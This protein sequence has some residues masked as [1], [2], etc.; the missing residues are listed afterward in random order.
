MSRTSESSHIFAF[1]LSLNLSIKKVKLCLQYVLICLFSRSTQSKID[2][3]FPLFAVCRA[4][5]TAGFSF[6]A[7]SNAQRGCCERLRSCKAGVGFRVLTSAFTNI[8]CA[9]Q[10]DVFKH[11]HPA[12]RLCGE[13]TN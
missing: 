2:A 10:V 5:W 1:D 6:V 9:G 7:A 11:I 4:G 13:A 8:I 3:I 12:E